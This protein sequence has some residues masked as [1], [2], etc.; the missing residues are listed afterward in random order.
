M[1]HRDIPVIYTAGQFGD[2]AGALIRQLVEAG[3]RIVAIVDA[4][5]GGVRIARRILNAAPSAQVVDVGEWPHPIGQVFTSDTSTLAGLH[6]LVDDPTV[7]WF[8]A[9]VLARGYPVEQELATV[10]IV[11]EL[12]TGR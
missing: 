10:K 2:D 7:G 3:R 11:E 5:L 6:S 12:V 1:H 4:D 8:A 9:A